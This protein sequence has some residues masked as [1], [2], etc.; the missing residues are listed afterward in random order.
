MARRYVKGASRVRRKLKRLPE[1][2]RERVGDTMGEVGTLLLRDMKSRVRVSDEAVPTDHKGR[3]REHLR[4]ALE[5][6]QSKDG[7]NVRVGI[8]GKRKKETFFFARWLEF[9]FRPGRP[10]SGTAS[11]TEHRGSI[12][13]R[14]RLKFPFMTPAWESRRQRARRRI[15][16]AVLR[17]LKTVANSRP[18]DA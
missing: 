2:V 3:P 17:A 5:M 18:S 15:K 4:D 1:E 9:G 10:R 7:L 6:R 11:I 16:L 12:G 8:M 13:N 14:R